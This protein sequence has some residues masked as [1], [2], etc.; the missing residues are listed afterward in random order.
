MAKKTKL[1]KELANRGQRYGPLYKRWDDLA[2][3]ADSW[4]GPVQRLA[5]EYRPL[6]GN[7]IAKV[8][9][10]IGKAI[11]QIEELYIATEQQKYYRLPPLLSLTFA[12][13]VIRPG[14]DRNTRIC[15]SCGSDIPRGGPSFQANTFIFASPSQRLQSGGS[16]TQPNVCGA[17]AAIAFI[18]PIKLGEGRLV[19]RLQRRNQAST[20]ML[21]D[22]LRMLSMGELNVVAGRYALLQAPEKLGNEP[23]IDRLGAIQYAIY[24]IATLFPA[25]VFFTY[26]PEITVGES[27]VPIQSRHAAW[28]RSLIEVFNLRKSTWRD[29]S[30]FAAFGRAIRFIQKEEVIFAIY[31]LL[32]AGFVNAQPFSR[33][34]A[35]Q[36]EDLRADHV[37]WLEMDNQNNRAEFYRDVAAMT[38]LLYAFCSY[39]HSKY[40][41][42]EQRREVRK[43]IERAGDPNQ[44]I[45]T[46][47]GDTQSEAATLYRSEDMHFGYEE[48]RRL[49]E[50]IGV[51]P[52][53]RETTNEQN[54][55][56]LR[57]Y[58]DDVVA[59]YTILFEQKYTKTKEQRDFLY[60]LQLSLHARFPHLIER[61]KETE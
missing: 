16:Q 58:F 4:T 26:S 44:F 53:T 61:Q 37:R 43:L 5:R 2:T 1:E 12:T 56:Q 49:L 13:S 9:T 55:K 20:Y 14:G 39:A 6:A 33:V 10:K 45:Y 7:Q 3:K 60:A 40:S 23:I 48:T 59:A 46:A 35:V 22:Q 52:E 54:Q 36:L 31:E 50:K 38:G 32:T 11:Q 21:E 18:S 51:S 29:K 57:L 28:M 24:K 15:Y 19:L 25:E 42:G 8:G 27:L 17:C 34:R 30:E 41:G 47:A